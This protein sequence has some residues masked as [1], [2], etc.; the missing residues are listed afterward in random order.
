MEASSKEKPTHFNILTTFIVP[1][2]P[3]FIRR[4]WL[5]LLLLTI[6][7]ISFMCLSESVCG[8]EN[9]MCTKMWN[10]D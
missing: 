2:L 6:F 8:L 3:Y 9:E 4:I 10:I 7:S 5:L 1:M